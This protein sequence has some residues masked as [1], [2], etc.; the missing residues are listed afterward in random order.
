MD[1]SRLKASAR[2]NILAAAAEVARQYGVLGLSI[3]RI[4]EV[5]KVSK[6]GFFYHFPSKE[7]L[8]EAVVTSE[9]DR[10]D[11]VV[12]GHT[13][14]GRT[15]ADAFVETMLEFVA[16]NGEMMGSV[17]A[18]LASGDAI[19]SLVVS[20]HQGWFKRLKKELGDEQYVLLT[21][22]VDGLIFSCSLRDAPPTKADQ[23]LTRRILKELVA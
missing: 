8:V 13:Q 16:T 7:A 1:T 22:A 11:R 18:A 9:L 4:I 23:A 2:D 14:E 3:D 12:E 15:Y 17:N 10:F 19:R 20:R 21:L 6:G 5:A